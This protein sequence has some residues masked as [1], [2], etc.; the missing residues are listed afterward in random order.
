MGRGPLSDGQIEETGEIVERGETLLQH[1]FW[2][3][4][5]AVRQ[6]SAAGS[7]STL[8]DPEQWSQ[9]QAWLREMMTNRRRPMRSRS[10]AIPPWT[11]SW[12]RVAAGSHRRWAG[13]RSI[14]GVDDPPSGNRAG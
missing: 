5:R 12:A 8:S 11:S 7:G 6:D 1:A 9:P 4:S 3:Q 2:P 10:G 13:G 14:P